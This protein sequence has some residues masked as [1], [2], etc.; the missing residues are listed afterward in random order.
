MD[1]FRFRFF[2]NSIVVDCGVCIWEKYIC[3]KRR[4]LCFGENLAFP[5]WTEVQDYERE[6]IQFLRLNELRDSINEVLF[7]YLITITPYF[8]VVSWLTW[9]FSRLEEEMGGAAVMTAREYVDRQLRY[10]GVLATADILYSRELGTYHRGPIG[11]EGLANKLGLLSSDVVDFNHPSFGKPLDPVSIYRSSLVAMEL[12]EEKQQPISAGRFQSILL[13]T[14]SGKELAKAFEANWS[15]LVNPNK[16]ATKMKWEIS[17]L[18]KLGKLIDLQ[19]LS[20]REKESKLLQNAA[21]SSMKYPKFYDDFVDTVVATIKTLDKAGYKASSSDISKAA[22]YRSAI[23]PEEKEVTL[24]LEDTEATALLAYHELHTHMSFG[25]DAILNGL[26]NLARDSFTGVSKQN[27]Y[28][29][30]SEA[31]N[32]KIIEQRGSVEVLYGKIG[33]SFRH[34]LGKYRTGS[35]PP[36]GKLGFESLREKTRDSEDNFEKIANGVI[37]LL[38][39]AVCQGFFKP[40]WLIRILPFHRKVFSAYTILE[41]YESLPPN[42]PIENWVKSAIDLVV[43]KHDDVASRKGLYA[44]RLENREDMLFYRADAEFDEQRGR[45]ANAVLWLSD[46][47]VIGVDQGLFTM[48]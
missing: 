33:K 19:G 29:K 13:P 46:I 43:Q 32:L 12:L 35:P 28:K 26:V 22:L 45:L 2:S 7:P 8:R 14:E 18:K 27:I 4:I 31:L 41:E 11:V 16:L 30:T 10:Y 40:N 25:A 38:Q 3:L 15:G 5:E 6:A 23:T 9:I 36:F 48:R 20:P 34:Y 1:V 24:S 47:G 17:L 44:R 42:A 39:S 37:I 21:R